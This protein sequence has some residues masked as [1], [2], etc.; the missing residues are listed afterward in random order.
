MMKEPKRMLLKRRLPNRLEHVNA[1][2]KEALDRF[3]NLSLP[4]DDILD[5]KSVA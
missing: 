4:E 5:R 3:A 1:F 2:I